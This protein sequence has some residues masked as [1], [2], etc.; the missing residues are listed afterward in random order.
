MSYSGRRKYYM[1]EQERLVECADTLKNI[2]SQECA[3][4][5]IPVAKEILREMFA[6]LDTWDR[7]RSGYYGTFCTERERYLLDTEQVMQ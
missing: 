6:R 3:V 1:C 5:D 2:F 4:D 7:L